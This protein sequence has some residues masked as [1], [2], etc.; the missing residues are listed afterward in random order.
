MIRDQVW[1]HLCN[2]VFKQHQCDLMVSHFQKRELYINIFL[3]VASSSSIAAW[4]IWEQLAII[5]GAIIAFSQVLTVVRPYLP[6]YKYIKEFNIKSVR[7]ANLQVDFEKLW[8]KMQLK[9]VDE[10]KAEET[11]FEL[12][13][14]FI[15]IEN[16]GDDTYFEVTNKIQHNA[17]L[18]VA[19]Y[20][21][22]NYSTDVKIS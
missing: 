16:F 1:T 18:F 12:K 9:K 8:Y 22:T 5:W 2:T 14:Q 20:L 10:D 3:A 13:K 7:F 11:F 6:Y 21:K 4:I 19:N 15:E 17:S